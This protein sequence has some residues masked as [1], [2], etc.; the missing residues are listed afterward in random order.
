MF[1]RF[2]SNFHKFF[3]VLFK[4]KK[5]KKKTEKFWKFVKI[6]FRNFLL[7]KI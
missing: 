4:K 5:K 3:P 7:Y 6:F 1:S 2:Y